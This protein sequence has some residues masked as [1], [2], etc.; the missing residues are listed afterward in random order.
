MSEQRFFESPQPIILPEDRPLVFLEGPVQGSPD[1][2]TPLAH[3]LLDRIPNLAVASPRPIKEHEDNL[4]SKDAVTKELAS[5]HQVAYEF[6]ARQQ[7][8]KFGVTA[9]WWAAQDLSLP[10]KE[11]RRYAKTT[12]VENGELW[13]WIAAHEEYGFVT[14]FDPN[15]KA[16]PDNSKDYILR[17]QHFLNIPVHDSLEA[18]EEA[19]VEAVANADR[20]PVPASTS[21]SVQRAWDQLRSEQPRTY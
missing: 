5:D 8:F 19:I 14:G 3:R 4:T 20:L 21:Q 15:F 13:G 1:W 7:T 2:Q 11:G 6:I 9:L 12:H 17:N 16:G 10:Y 18:F